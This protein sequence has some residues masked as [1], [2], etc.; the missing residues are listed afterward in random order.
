MV[1]ARRWR[2]AGAVQQ[3][4]AEGQ[5][6]HPVAS[7][8]VV[9]VLHEGELLASVVVGLKH[10][11]QIHEWDLGPVRMVPTSLRNRLEIVVGGVLSREWRG[12]PGHAGRSRSACR[13]RPARLPSLRMLPS[14]RS[15]LASNRA[16]TSDP[17]HGPLFENRRSR[18]RSPDVDTPGRSRLLNIADRIAKEAVSGG[19]VPE[20]DGHVG[21]Q[22]ALGRKEVSVV[23]EDVVVSLLEGR[24]PHRGEDH[25]HPGWLDGDRFEEVAETL[26]LVAEAVTSDRQVHGLDLAA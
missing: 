19:V 13:R 15:S 18:L 16:G 3:C 24:D 21:N 4:V 17:A 7:D 8:V 20:G 5:A 9:R 14:R 22:P 23:D 25:D 10:R 26:L 12:T 1:I 6:D 11:E 2:L